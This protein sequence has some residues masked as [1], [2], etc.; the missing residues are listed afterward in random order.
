MVSRDADTRRTVQIKLAKLTRL[1]DALAVFSDFLDGVGVSVMQVEF[2]LRQFVL[3]GVM[4]GLVHMVGCLWLSVGRD[5]ARRGEGWMVGTLT[6]PSFGITEREDGTYDVGD[7]EYVHAQ[8]IDAVYWAVVTMTSVGYGDLVPS[9]TTER[10]VAILVI[11]MGTFLMAYIIG[12]FSTVSTHAHL[13]KP[14]QLARPASQK[15]GILL[16]L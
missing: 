1:R 10:T 11:A 3:L 16:S 5:G 2:V 13:H 14:H 15:M 7:N 9:T 6:H 12:T 8:Y 4:L